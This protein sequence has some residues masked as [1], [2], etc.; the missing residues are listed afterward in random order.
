MKIL[1]TILFVF[2]LYL[3]L[4]SCRIAQDPKPP[5]QGV[6]FQPEKSEY[7]VFFP[8]KPVI[9]EMDS[10]LPD[11]R[12]IKVIRAE[13][14]IT[15]EDCFLRADYTPI[16]SR[17]KPLDDQYL[18]DLAHQYAKQEGLGTPS[19]SIENTKLGK[20][21]RIRGYKTLNGI[22]CTYECLNYSGFRL[23]E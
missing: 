13:L 18:L 4:A 20:A 19:V 8:M 21:V 14:F 2:V 17:T 1:N 11:G 5:D 10:A 15:N 22:P 3:P 16:P 23:N 12:R 9:Q 7:F 6:K